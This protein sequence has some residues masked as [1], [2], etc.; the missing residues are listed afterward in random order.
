MYQLWIVNEIFF[1]SS[2]FR[3]VSSSPVSGIINTI[4]ILFRPFS[5]VYSTIFPCS[6][7][8]AFYLHTIEKALLLHQPEWIYFYIFILF[9]MLRTLKCIFSSNSPWLSNVQRKILYACGRQKYYEAE[10]ILLVL[11][12]KRSIAQPSILLWRKM[13]DI[14][15][16]FSPAPSFFFFR[17]SL[18][19]L[20]SKRVSAKERRKKPEKERKLLLVRRLMKAQGK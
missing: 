14:T 4:Y 3:C 1:I 8:E 6:S 17:F 10:G 19:F 16:Y 7:V 11:V 9:S 18:F 13:Y 20:C 15:L 12:D 2:S 5:F